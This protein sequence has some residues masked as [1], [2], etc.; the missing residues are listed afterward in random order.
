MYSVGVTEE[1]RK[2]AD[3]LFLTNMT[4]CVDNGLQWK[5]LLKLRMEAVTSYYC[6]VR[7]LGKGRFESIHREVTT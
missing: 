3:E 7:T 5:W 1:D 4:I 6:V 2:E